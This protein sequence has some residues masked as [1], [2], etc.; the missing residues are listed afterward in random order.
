[1][2]RLQKRLNQLQHLKLL[3]REKCQRRSQI[4]KRIMNL[5][6]SSKKQSRH[7]KRRYFNSRV[8]RI[9]STKKTFKSNKNGKKYRCKA[10]SWKELK[11]NM[12]NL[13]FQFVKKSKLYLKTS[14]ESL[15][16]YRT[17]KR[18]SSHSSLILRWSQNS[19]SKK[20]S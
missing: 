11:E 10:Q 19:W 18:T 20:T 13:N 17:Q 9:E 16:N 8:K 5:W 1:M 4:L 7:L 15:I 14:S 3:I 12:L 6:R 2:L